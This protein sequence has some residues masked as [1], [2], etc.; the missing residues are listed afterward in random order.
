[1]LILGDVL[2]GMN[3]MTGTPRACRSRRRSSRPTRRATAVRRAGSP[4]C[5]RADA[6]SA[7]GRRCATR[8]PLR[9]LHRPAARLTARWRE[10]HLHRAAGDGAFVPTEQARGPWDPRALHG[11]APAALI[12]ARVRAHRARRRAALRAPRRSSSCARAAG[13][14]DAHHARR[15]PGSTRAGARCRAAAPASSRSCRASALRD[16]PRSPRSGCAAAPAR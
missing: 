6:A 9:G 16:Q 3:L 4:R 5:A 8:A 13:A 14:A 7:T 15:A 11:G 10:Q 1:M 2:N 12:T